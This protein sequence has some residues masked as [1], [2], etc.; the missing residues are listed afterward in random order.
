MDKDLSFDLTPY[1]GNPDLYIV[2]EKELPKS[3]N[4]Y[5]WT[6]KN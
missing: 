2:C 1:V 6:A 4:D 5:K 3:V